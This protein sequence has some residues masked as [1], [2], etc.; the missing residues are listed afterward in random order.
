MLVLGPETRVADQY[1]SHLKG[2]T[3]YSET[4]QGLVCMVPPTQPKTNLSF[5][6]QPKIRSMD[7]KAVKI[8]TPGFITWCM[9]FLT[10]GR[11][12]ACPFNGKDRGHRLKA[13]WVLSHVR[14]TGTDSDKTCLLTVTVS[15]W[16]RPES[17]AF[18]R[19]T[20]DRSV[21]ILKPS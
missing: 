21:S 7:P 12:S 2:R 8:P 5:E 16:D 1:Q 3:L 17:K 14:A 9:F 4:S 20:F 15:Q 18:I 10:D 6:F 13:A 11:T 19:F